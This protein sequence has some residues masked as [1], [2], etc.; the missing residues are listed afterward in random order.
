MIRNKEKASGNLGESQPE[1][2]E[3]DNEKVI[4]RV[5]DVET[6]ARKC[7]DIATPAVWLPGQ[8]SLLSI[9]GETLV[10]GDYGYNEDFALGEAH[11]YSVLQYT[12]YKSMSQDLSS[13]VLAVVSDGRGDPFTYLTGFDVHTTFRVCFVTSKGYLGMGSDHMLAG[14]V[15]CIPQGSET[16]YVLREED[17]HYILIGQCYM[18]VSPDDDDVCLTLL[19]ILVE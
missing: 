5:E 15:I 13:E 4:V 19:T 1:G 17:G 10:A 6:A 8:R 16:P 7:L 14:D 3:E 12:S 11:F 2:E 18:S 9:I